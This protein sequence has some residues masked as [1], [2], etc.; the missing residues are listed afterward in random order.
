MRRAIDI[1]TGEREKGGWISYP[2]GG[3]FVHRPPAR[4]T[5]IAMPVTGG[6]DGPNEDLPHGD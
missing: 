1:G 2:S 5:I 4:A 3:S 6:R